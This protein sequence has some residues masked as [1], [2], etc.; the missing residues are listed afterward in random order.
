[1]K[2]KK[3]RFLIAA[4]LLLLGS[5]ALLAGYNLYDSYRAGLAA[6]E[7]V[8]YL[9]ELIPTQAIQQISNAGEAD[10]QEESVPVKEQEPVEVAKEVVI[11]D[12]MLNPE[13]EMPTGRYE[14]QDYIGILEIPAIQL[15]IPVISEW[16]YPRLRI[17][18]CRYTGSAYLN[19]MV[20]AAH[21]Y[22]L[23]FGSLHTLHE[24]D[25]VIFT[26]VDGNR[27]VYRV[28]AKETLMPNDVEE[29]TDSGWDLSLFTCTVGG[30]Y[31]VTVRCM[32]VTG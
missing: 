31:R 15:K 25:A 28:E 14:D 1:M 16:S 6:Q 23:H 9:E 19:N 27:F 22:D 13:M 29:M 30:S 7:S 5:A 26:D 3:G 24:G 21:N 10:S 18:P 2:K 17:A 11:P 12:Y 20:I 8:G 32:L 4:G